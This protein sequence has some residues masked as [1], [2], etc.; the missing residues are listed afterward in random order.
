MAVPH[1]EILQ[2]KK[3]GN[4][5]DRTAVTYVELDMHLNYTTETGFVKENVALSRKDTRQDVSQFIHRRSTGFL[6]RGWEG[7]GGYLFLKPTLTYECFFFSR[8][9]CCEAKQNP[10]SGDFGSRGGGR[11]G[12]SHFQAPTLMPYAV[13]WNCEVSSSS[14]RPCVA[15]DISEVRDTPQHGAAGGG[16]TTGSQFS[17]LFHS[18][19][20]FFLL[21]P[22]KITCIYHTK[23]TF[24]KQGK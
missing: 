1:S 7:G 18:F 9:P 13:G 22:V 8:Y 2:T 12:G 23:K 3:A 20:F 5:Q 10:E 16:K 6:D 14:V 21:A 19:E 24:F 11:E 17:I 4:C 15:S